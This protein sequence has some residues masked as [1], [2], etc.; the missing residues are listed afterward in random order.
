MHEKEADQ[1]PLNR[2][3]QHRHQNIPGSKVVIG[4]D[5]RNDGQDK[6]RHPNLYISFRVTF[7]LFLF[8]HHITRSSRVTEIN[9]SISSPLNANKFPPALPVYNKPN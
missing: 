5:N 3:H 8:M 2:R 9:K 6:E 4:N 7:M 1:S